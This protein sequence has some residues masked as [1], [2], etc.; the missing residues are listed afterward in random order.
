MVSSF[1]RQVAHLLNGVGVEGGGEVGD[2]E[3]G[4]GS[5]EGDGASGGDEG[6]IGVDGDGGDHGV[7]GLEHGGNS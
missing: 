7:D 5:G 1:Q 2:R 3:G 4:F 6:A